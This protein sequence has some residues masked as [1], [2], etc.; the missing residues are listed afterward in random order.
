MKRSLTDDSKW[1][2][3]NECID[4]DASE[5]SVREY[6]ELV[7]RKVF[8]QNII[9]SSSVSGYFGYTANDKEKT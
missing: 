5:I 4:M 7:S 3:L 9:L 6:D 2:L 8:K 1:N